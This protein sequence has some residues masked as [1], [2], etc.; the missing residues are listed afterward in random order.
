MGSLQWVVARGAK[1]GA[2]SGGGVTAAG[3][4]ALAGL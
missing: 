1:V 4:L 2:T 3:S